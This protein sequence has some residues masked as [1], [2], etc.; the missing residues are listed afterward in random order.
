MSQGFRAVAA[1]ASALSGLLA[2]GVPMDSR[3]A[4]PSGCVTCHLDETMLARNLAVSTARKSALQS[5][6]G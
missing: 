3:A 2:A 6:A 5:G 4:E 1:V